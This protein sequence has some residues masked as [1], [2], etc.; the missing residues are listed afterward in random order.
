MTSIAKAPSAAKL[1][2]AP[3]KAKTKAPVREA[4]GKEIGGSGAKERASV[5]V[6]RQGLGDCILVRVKRENGDDFKL[7]IDCG[8]VLGTENASGKMTAVVEDVVHEADGKIDV[9]A[10]THEHWDHLSAFIQ[11]A[12]SF[13]KLSVG[14]VWV[15]WTEDPND[16]LAKQLKRELGKAE[17]TLQACA[18]AFRAAGNGANADMLSDIALTPMS[19]VAAANTSTRA[20]FDRA[21]NMAAPQ[22]P[23]MWRPTDA[24]F[25]IPDANARI[26][27]LGPPHDPRLI[28]KINPSTSNPE[29]YGL[30]ADGCAVLPAG[31]LAALGLSGDEDSGPPFHRRVTIPLRN[32]KDLA[33]FGQQD[34]EGRIERFFTKHFY[35]GDD[36]WRRIDGD[37]LGSAAELALALQSYTNNTSLVLALELGNIGTGDVLLFAADAQVG[38]WESWQDWQCEKD[39]RKI[40]GP[41][42]LKR[43]IFYKVGHHGSHNATLKQRGVDQMDALKAA[44][45]PVDEEEALKKHWGRLPLS[46]L[47]AALEK[48][49]ALVLRTDQKP[50]G[51]PDNVVIADNYFEV[52]I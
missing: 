45:I 30:A 6:Y 22:P 47:I 40:T 15:A 20:A 31:V 37:W 2:R 9:L 34:P 52:R 49:K 42:L 14:A 43:T 23:R 18:S 4:S 17:K 25:E 5:R 10:I 51:P 35:G 16:D 39:G 11:A 21:K 38:N 32:E 27:A 24:P 48:K 46:D 26:Y 7:L 29:T 28:R 13:K 12:D 44:I 1:A 8:V 36:D 19:A 3:R 50:S 33:S 41:D